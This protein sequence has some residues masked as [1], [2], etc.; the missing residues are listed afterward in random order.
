[1]VGSN[2]VVRVAGV[3]FAG[4]MAGMVVAIVLSRGSGDVDVDAYGSGSGAGE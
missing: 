4:L 2:N 3:L 1:M